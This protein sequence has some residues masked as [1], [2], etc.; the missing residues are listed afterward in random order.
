MEIEHIKITDLKPAEYNPRRIGDED[1]QK[2]KNSISTFGLVDPII[3]NLKNMHIVGGHQ[4]YDVLLD[5]HMLDNDF[6]AELPM[7][8]LGDVGFV[9]TD[10]E[11]SIRD[12]DHEKALNL[13]LNKINGEWD[14]LKLQPLLEE[15]E[16]SPIDI[17]LTGFSEHELEELNIDTAEETGEGV[18]E[19]DY[20][21]PEELETDIKYG[22]L[23][24]L[25]DH[26]LLCGDATS[27]DD[28]TS[29]LAAGGERK[30]DLLFT[31]P[32]YNVNIGSINHP[33]FKVRPIENDDMSTDDFKVFCRKWV[34]NIKSF[35]EGCCYICAG[36]S[37]DG[38]IMFTI[39]DELLHNSTT[40]IWNKDTFTLG[41]GKYQ[42]KYEPIWFGW[43]ESGK[44]FTD[45][46]DL[47]NVFDINRP[48]KSELHPTMK[49]LE[50]IITCLEHNPHA[51]TVLDLFGG[52]GSTLISC[53]QTNR[54]CYMMELTPKYCQVIINRWETF[55]GK[56]AEKIN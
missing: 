9:F 38:R 55:T 24:R 27:E 2:L 16:L 28:V 43:N 1:Y 11:L 10:T 39:C 44:T 30:V 3:V 51:E 35:V 41:R 29:L 46:R 56:K 19:D 37:A 45:K 21:E 13:A 5:E 49:P 31:D 42:N 14:E 7:I 54:T 25:G 6:L 18:V 52:S 47:C 53:E 33:K 32:P 8:R 4:R 17:Q 36:Q 12:D 23:F 50:L 15:L 22:D 40:I 26:Y 20:V 48:K 34:N